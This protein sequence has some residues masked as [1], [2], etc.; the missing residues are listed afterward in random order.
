MR[1]LHSNNI[2][3]V[4]LACFVSNIG[5]IIFNSLMKYDGERLRILTSAQTYQVAGRAGRYGKK[6]SKGLVTT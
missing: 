4:L 1:K 5:R 6:H 3:H 2:L